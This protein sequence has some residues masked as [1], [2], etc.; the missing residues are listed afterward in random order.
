V[1]LLRHLHGQPVSQ[2]RFEPGTAAATRA[3]DI[4]LNFRILTY[5]SM[6]HTATESETTFAPVGF[7]CVKRRVFTVT[8]GTQSA[9]GYRSTT[10]NTG[11]CTYRQL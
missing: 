10:V 11:V 2:P 5:T 1:V 6:L 3:V 9:S 8:G 4:S 7:E